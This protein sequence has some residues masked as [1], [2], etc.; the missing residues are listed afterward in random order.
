MESKEYWRKYLRQRL[1]NLPDKVERDL[2][3]VDHIIPILKPFSKVLLYSALPDEPDLSILPKIL[4][5]ID[6]YYPKVNPVTRTLEFI[7]PKKFNVGNFGVLEPIGERTISLLDLE[8]LVVPALG[9]SPS[10]H[11]LGRGGGYYDRTLEGFSRNKLIGV[12]YNA[13]VSLDFIPE[14]H[15]SAVGTVI[16]ESGSFFLLDEN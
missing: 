11:R 13:A 12:T 1:S 16:T 2:R 5:N 9:F 3:I 14:P 6:F 10:G 15:D 8:R 4:D 7:Y